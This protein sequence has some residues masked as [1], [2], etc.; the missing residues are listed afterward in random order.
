MAANAACSAYAF[1]A[2]CNRI[3]SLSSQIHNSYTKD[4]T[5]PQLSS[6]LSS[7][8]SFSPSLPLSPSPSLPLSLSL[9]TLIS[10]RYAGCFLWRSS[11]RGVFRICIRSRLQPHPLPLVRLPRPARVIC[12][13]QV[14]AGLQVSASFCVSGLVFVPRHLPACFVDHRSPCAVY[15]FRLRVQN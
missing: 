5:N 2:A 11:K 15:G 7:N 9:S 4:K 10:E 3:L 14:F 8:L 1:A 12:R 6:R 13:P